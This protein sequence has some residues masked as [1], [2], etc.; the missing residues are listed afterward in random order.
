L[1]AVA[2]L[3]LALFEF[4]AI[5]KHNRFSVK[6]LLTFEVNYDYTV[7][8]LGIDLWN[9]GVGPAVISSVSVF[10]DDEDVTGPE[11]RALINALKV[12]DLNYKFVQHFALTPGAA[13]SPGERIP[14]LAFASDEL[15]DEKRRHIKNALP[16]IGIEVN[17]ESVYEEPFKAE[18]GRNLELLGDEVWKKA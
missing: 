11:E 9:K 14:I 10:V 16:R 2:A 12:V 15:D 18:L 17:F 4:H 13:I 3:A 8:G 7:R 5:R 1:I 6:P